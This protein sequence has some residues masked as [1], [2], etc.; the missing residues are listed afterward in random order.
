MR[1]KNVQKYSAKCRGKQWSENPLSR[2]GKSLERNA[3]IV[4]PSVDTTTPISVAVFVLINQ[5]KQW[6]ARRCHWQHDSP[7]RENNNKIFLIHFPRAISEKNSQKYVCMIIHRYAKQFCFMK[8]VSTPV[9]TSHT[10]RPSTNPSVLFWVC[11]R[12]EVGC[13]NLPLQ[14]RHWGRSSCDLGRPTSGPCKSG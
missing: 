7:R 11:A 13:Q 4:K 6:H 1:W 14:W 12:R 2:L 5:W 3:I 10:S 8:L 9:H